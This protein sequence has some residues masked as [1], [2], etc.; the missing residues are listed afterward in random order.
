MADQQKTN[1]PNLCK[2]NNSAI[3]QPF[4]YQR[5]TRAMAALKAFLPPPEQREGNNDAKREAQ[6]TQPTDNDS[7]TQPSEAHPTY[8]LPDAPIPEFQSMQTWC[9]KDLVRT[10]PGRYKDEER[11]RELAKQELVRR[12]FTKF[13]EPAGY[14][15]DLSLIDF[16]CHR[17]GSHECAK[18]G[19]NP[20]PFP[21]MFL[22]PDAVW[23][24]Y[25]KPPDK[26]GLIICLDCFQK[27]VAQEDGG[28]YERLNGKIAGWPYGYPLPDGGYEELFSM[29]QPEMDEFYERSVQ[30]GF[31]RWLETKRDYTPAFWIRHKQGYWVTLQ[32]ARRW[33]LQP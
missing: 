33:K 30:K 1:V 3:R 27:L 18:C 25:A 4:D 15:P 12:G 17:S 5:L 29:T 11:D 9:L 32:Y 23:K 19:C 10:E 2:K 8:A 14:R 24:F 31:W 22:A 28:A 7:V 21:A 16:F 26:S 13:D 20:T 6:L